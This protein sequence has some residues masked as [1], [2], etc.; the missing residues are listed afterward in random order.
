MHLSLPLVAVLPNAL[1]AIPCIHRR[2]LVHASDRQMVM[3]DGSPYGFVLHEDDKQ[4]DKRNLSTLSQ[5]VQQQRTPL[6]LCT[7]VW[8]CRCD[9]P[10]SGGGGEVHSVTC[11]PRRF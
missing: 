2:A 4:T 1:P 5:Q 10:N 6:S 11:A 9:L 7:G 8:L 3:H